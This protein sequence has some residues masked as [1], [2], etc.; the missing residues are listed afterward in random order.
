MSIVSPFS[1]AHICSLLLGFK[2]RVLIFADDN[3]LVHCLAGRA[4]S[5][6]IVLVF[7]MVR[8]RLNLRQAYELTKNKKP[9]IRPNFGFWNQLIALEKEVERK[10]Y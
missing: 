9:D 7:L 10:G 5:A 6:T 2:Y 4:R 3:V 8:M 1:W